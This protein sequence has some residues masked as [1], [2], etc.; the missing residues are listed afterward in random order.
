MR[1]IGIERLCVFGMPPVAFVDL[2]AELGAAFLG[3]GLTPA[4]RQ[5]NPHGYPAWSLRD[6]VLLRETRAALRDTRVRIGLVEGFGVVPGRDVRE[7]AADLDLVAALG[8]ERINAVS[9]DRDAARTRDAFALLAEMAGARGIDVAIEIG[10]GPI[11]TLDDA[12]E[13]A[14]HVGRSN[15]GLLIDTM[16]FFRMGSSTAELAAVRPM[17]VSYVQLCDAPEEPRFASY[18]DEALHERLPPGEGELPLEALMAM[19][20]AHVPVSIEIPQRALAQ[21][22]VPAADRLSACLAAAERLLLRAFPST[23]VSA[24]PARETTDH[25]DAAPPGHG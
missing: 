24:H 11:A 18:I 8:G 10:P 17:P 14:W 22:G 2:A 20:P 9:I 3:I 5:D 12:L 6:P 19:M 13:A 7:L 4:T 25:D 16:H 23:D 15:F 21:A 1:E